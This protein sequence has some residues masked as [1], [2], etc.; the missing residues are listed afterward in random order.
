M[1]LLPLRVHPRQLLDLALEPRLLLGVQG[2]ALARLAE[3]LELRHQGAA[4]LRQRARP[5]LLLLLLP[6]LLRAALPQAVPLGLELLRLAPGAAQALLELPRPLRQGLPL[7]HE[8]RGLRGARA[9]RLQQPHGPLALLQALAQLQHLRVPGP[10]QRGEALRLRLQPGVLGLGARPARPR[11][12]APGPGEEGRA[13]GGHGGDEAALLGP[14]GVPAE[15]GHDRPPGEPLHEHLPGRVLHRLLGN[16]DQLV[17]GHDAEAGGDLVRVHLRHYV[18][19]RQPLEL[20]PERAF[21]CKHDFEDRDC[22]GWVLHRS[23]LLHGWASIT[24]SRELPQQRLHLLVPLGQ[25]LRLLL[26]PALPLPER[27]AELLEL[28]LGS[29]RLALLRGA[30]LVHGSLRRKQLGLQALLAGRAGAAALLELAA[31]LR[32]LRL[33]LLLPGAGLVLPRVRLLPGLGL[34]RAAP[35]RGQALALAGGREGRPR[36]LLEL[37]RAGLAVLRLAAEGLAAGPRGVELRLEAQ[38]PLVPV[39]Q[40]LRQA[41]HP[42]LRRTRGLRRL[43]APVAA[44]L[45]LHVRAVHPAAPKPR[46]RARVPRGTLHLSAGGTLRSRAIDLEGRWSAVQIFRAAGLLTSQCRVCFTSSVLIATSMLADGVVHVSWHRKVNAIVREF[47]RVRC[48]S[49]CNHFIERQIQKT[50]G[51]FGHVGG[52][53]LCCSAGLFNSRITFITSYQTNWII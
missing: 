30:G 28:A 50:V 17:P 52:S 9:P 19:G 26:Q 27:E 45:E 12:G 51:C 34:Q 25:R 43:R 10:E 46:G 1:Q 33:Q 24:D 11:H 15:P 8:P 23:R 20:Q 39:P 18:W 48:A 41:P 2:Q 21:Q 29:G 49:R 16:R 47:L 37:R 7:L 36:G 13:H 31:E 38:Q 53:C 5:L 32:Q 14:A 35:L 40:V 22:P 42:R 3:A 6:R 44:A 4:A